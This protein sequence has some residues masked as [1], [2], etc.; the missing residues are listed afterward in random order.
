MRFLELAVQNFLSFG[1][2]QTLALADAG[3]VLVEGDNRD[4]SIASSNGA[5][6]SAI[7]DALLWALYGTTMRGYQADEVVNRHAGQDCLVSVTFKT[8]EHWQVVRARKHREH[9][10][11]LLL[12]RNGVD[13]SAGTSTA[14]QAQIERLVAMSATTFLASTIYGQ[15]RAYRFSQL[16][17]QE[18]KAVLDEALG[19]ARFARAG[20]VAREAF[21]DRQTLVSNLTNQLESGQAKL[22]DLAK[23]RREL[24][25]ARKVER[26]RRLAH[27]AELG[28]RL[29]AGRS[30]R[31]DLAS[32]TAQAPAEARR[33]LA[34]LEA[35]ANLARR[36][37]E[38]EDGARRQLT[39]LLEQAE[40]RGRCPACGQR[41]AGAA[42]ATRKLLS[43][44]K[45]SIQAARRRVLVETEKLTALNSKIEKQR[46]RID[47]A[48]AA[49]RERRS[50]N[51]EIE[52]LEHELRD[53]KRAPVPLTALVQAIDDERVTLRQELNTVRSELTG[54]TLE[55]TQNRF[56]SEG[57]SQRG[58]RSF[59]LDNALPL[60]NQTAE[61]Y[62][63]ALSQDGLSV[64]FDAQDTLKSGKLVERFSIAVAS[65][66]GA[67]SYH[68]HSAGELAKADLVIGLAVQ[69]LIQRHR[70]AQHNVIFFDECLESMDALAA[71]TSIAFLV[72]L[73]RD[74]E[75]IFV[76]THSE[77][78]KP[79]FHNVITV[80]KKNGFSR[81]VAN[82]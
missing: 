80:V 33:V 39:D 43:D 47:R 16:D 73:F 23:R 58:L 12:Y 45:V 67:G 51:E 13:V 62:C 50:V 49:E 26:S 22:A 34:D 8:A 53:L 78:L 5:G 69:H 31:D 42:T 40:Q 74:H 11:K 55:A 66:H 32:R 35:A 81:I 30:K 15:S 17:D 76:V 19:T 3:L 60:L 46:A 77:A 59:L 41:I 54:Y 63:R 7:A 57:F 6:K 36:R 82:R 21:R 37:L 27:Q 70:R 48:A 72:D 14:T 18:R 25:A 2:K 29:A 20:E 61:R 52:H 10:N 65:A 4:E 56:W 1:R 28:A 68:G 79:F 24:V 9:K 44:T 64:R 38:R 75:S 71:E